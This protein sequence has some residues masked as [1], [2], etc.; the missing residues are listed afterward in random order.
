MYV[1]A[2]L[3][4]TVCRFIYQP[5]M[6]T[7]TCI[8]VHSLLTIEILEATLFTK[9]YKTTFSVYV[10]AVATERFITQFQC[11]LGVKAKFYRW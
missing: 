5:K 9:T 11:I 3:Y 2:A 4:S 6:H 7:I 1:S 10:H 8:I